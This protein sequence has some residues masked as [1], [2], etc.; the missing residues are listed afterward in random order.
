M[1]KR[2][3][4]KDKNLISL[5][6]VCDKVIVCKTFNSLLIN[7]NK[8]NNYKATILT[9]LSQKSIKGVNNLFCETNW[10]NGN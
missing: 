7:N 3:R 1:K 6:F 8:Y 10:A 9:V 4:P 5:S 2:N